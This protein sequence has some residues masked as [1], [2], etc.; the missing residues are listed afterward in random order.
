M[1]SIASGDSGKFFMIAIAFC[2]ILAGLGDDFSLLLYNRYLLAR[3]HREDHETA[4]ATAIREVDRKISSAPFLGTC[5]A[6]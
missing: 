5:P 6:H 2:S 3:T 1:S 4:V